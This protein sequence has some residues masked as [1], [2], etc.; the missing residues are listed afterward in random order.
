MR[1]YCCVQN[2]FKDCW[3]ASIRA[4]CSEVE[5]RL[6]KWLPL[7]MLT[8]LRTDHRCSTFVLYP[9]K[10]RVNTFSLWQILSFLLLIP[11]VAFAAIL[12]LVISL[13]P[14][15]AYQSLTLLRTHQRIDD[16]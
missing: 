10:C 16:V 3:T 2:D 4:R 13:K 9:H 15:I 12:L 6:T 5:S 7:Q 14:E 11:F 8:D 1:R